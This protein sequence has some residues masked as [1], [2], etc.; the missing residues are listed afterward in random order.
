MVGYDYVEVCVCVGLNGVDV[1]FFVGSVVECF[2]LGV[3]MYLGV[4]IASGFSERV[5]YVRGINVIFV[6]VIYCFYE[7]LFIK[8]GEKLFGFI[9]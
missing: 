3:M 6:G 2:D 7:V 5:G 4:I 9:Y 8:D 1:L